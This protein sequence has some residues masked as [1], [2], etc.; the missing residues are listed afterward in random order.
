MLQYCVI[1]QI[2]MFFSSSNNHVIKETN[3]AN[4]IILYG[5]VWN[6]P[7]RGQGGGEKKVHCHHVNEEML[8]QLRFYF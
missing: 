7:E 6:M 8:Q 3:C 4:Q 5:R 2:I 1:N